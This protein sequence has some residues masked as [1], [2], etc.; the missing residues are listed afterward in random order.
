MCDRLSDYGT[1]SE[2]WSLAPLQSLFPI[3]TFGRYLHLCD[4][5]T[6]IKCYVKCYLICAVHEVINSANETPKIL[7]QCK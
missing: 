4:H 2:L 6:T 7:V 5:A 1:N 3:S